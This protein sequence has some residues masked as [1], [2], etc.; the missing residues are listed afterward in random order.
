M[1]NSRLHAALKAL[2]GGLTT[3]ANYRAH[4]DEKAEDRAF[5]TETL[6]RQQ[7][8]QERLSTMQMEHQSAEG[9]KSRQ[10]A[11]AEADKTREHSL[12]LFKLQDAS[13][14]ARHAQSMGAQYAQIQLARE[15]LQA[16]TE[17]RKLGRKLGV[18]ETAVKTLA[19][20]RDSLVE[21][22][23]EEIKTSTEKVHDPAQRQQV[24]SD[25]RER[26]NT[27]IQ[28]IDQK[29]KVELDDYASLVG[30]GKGT[31]SVGPMEFGEAGSLSSRSSKLPGEV[32]NKV[33]EAVAAL[34][35]RIGSVDDNR[36]K[37]L[38][39][40]GGI[41]EDQLDAAVARARAIAQGQ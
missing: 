39:R 14:N 27:D 20:Q 35:D 15:Q 34:G 19:E 22:M 18:A 6:E 10:H 7:A 3:I 12:E 29:L 32:E 33:S 37:T 1:S 31:A 2:S 25:I 30:M 4:R 41:P 24:A 8:F 26:Y 40:K 16:T 23:N 5:Q 28:K 36:L 17:D 11:S 21:T 38:F 13:A 9:E